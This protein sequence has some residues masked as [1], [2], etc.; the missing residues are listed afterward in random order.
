[1]FTTPLGWIVILCAALGAGG[2][3]FRKWMA[4]VVFFALAVLVVWLITR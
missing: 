3:I 2:L 4:A 1:M